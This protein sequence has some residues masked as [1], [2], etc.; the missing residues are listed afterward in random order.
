MNYFTETTNG[1]EE[2]K[3]FP[4]RNF[5]EFKK[6]VTNN[7]ILGTNIAMDKARDWVMR[8][9]DAPKGWMYFGYILVFLPYLFT[10]FYL[11]AAFVLHNY[12]LIIYSVVPIL[13]IF[14][15][16]PFARK[17]FK[18]HYYFIILYVILSLFLKEL[19][20]PLFWLPLVFLYLATNQLYEGSAQIVREHLTKDEMLLCVFWKWWDLV[21]YLK[22]GTQV[23]QRYYEYGGNTLYFEDIK[24]EWKDYI[25]LQDKTVNKNNLS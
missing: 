16:N 1:V 5:E 7:D 22:D 13:S 9:L 2:L 3:H 20:S 19:W 11:I 10:I 21:I 23:S 6:A 14:F 4:Y 15:F 12:W 8:G 17:A 18:I 24:K 25:E